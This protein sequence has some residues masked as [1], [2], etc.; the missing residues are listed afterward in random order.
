MV[1]LLNLSEARLIDPL[2]MKHYD[3]DA[4]IPNE[5][6]QKYLIFK[7]FFRYLTV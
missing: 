4:L 7:N 3:Q 2:F 5:D 6:F 1:H